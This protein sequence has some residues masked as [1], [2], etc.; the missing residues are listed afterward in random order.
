MGNPRG[1]K[2]RG[3]ATHAASRP[4]AQRLSLGRGIDIGTR[5]DSSGLARNGRD[6]L[7]YDECPIKFRRAPRPRLDGSVQHKSRARTRSSR[8]GNSV[9]VKA[10]EIELEAAGSICHDSN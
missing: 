4:R 7:T 2:A 3:N 6:A 1:G 10:A 8:T 5:G 9:P